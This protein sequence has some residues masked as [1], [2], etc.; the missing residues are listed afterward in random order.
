MASRW[1]SSASACTRASSS[2]LPSASSATSSSGLRPAPRLACTSATRGSAPSMRLG[3]GRILKSRPSSNES[4]SS[5]RSGA[6]SCN[7]AFVGLKLSSLLRSVRSSR[8]D[9]HFDRRPSG[10]SSPGRSSERKA[11]MSSSGRSGIGSMAAG[12]SAAS[13]S[14]GAGAMARDGKGLICSSRARWMSTA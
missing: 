2:C 6:T 4:S 1:P 5:E 9:F 12:V 7:V 13:S 10:V 3:K 14:P 11:S 8:R